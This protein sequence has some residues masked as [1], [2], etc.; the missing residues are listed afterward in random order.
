MRDVDQGGCTGAGQ[1]LG[2]RMVPE[3]GGDVGVDAGRDDL[4]QVRVTGA[5]AQRD[6]PDETVRVTGR[7]DAPGGCRQ[8]G[9]DPVGEGAQGFGCRE[10]ADPAD[11]VRPSGFGDSG[12]VTVTPSAAASASETPGSAESALVWAQ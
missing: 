5:A 6:R 10:R 1:V 9:I 3:V 12:P 8:G 2:C 11:P 4:L 7:P